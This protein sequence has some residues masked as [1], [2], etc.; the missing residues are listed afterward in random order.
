MSMADETCPKCKASMKGEPVPEKYRVHDDDCEKQQE[1][2]GRCFCL[3]YGDT[4]HFSRVMG[5]EVS[6]V[7]DGIL[8]WTCPDCNHAW[9]RF[10]GADD[11]R[12]WAGFAH[13][14][15]WNAANAVAELDTWA[16]GDPEA[17]H[18][19][20][21]EILL[22]NVHPDIAAAYRRLVSRCNWWATA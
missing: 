19:A 16:G 9:P 3:P 11:R 21:D 13:A 18:G 4:T 17:E 14:A 8:F 15:N 2:F 1:S 7:Y 10:W 5:H 6:G 12:C 20:A 22:A